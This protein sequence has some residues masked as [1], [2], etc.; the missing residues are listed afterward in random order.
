MTTASSRLLNSSWIESSSVV[1]LRRRSSECDGK[2]PEATAP[3]PGR[4]GFALLRRAGRLRGVHHPL[5]PL[6]PRRLLPSLPHHGRAPEL[7]EG[8]LDE[9]LGSLALGHKL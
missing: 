8:V 7:E 5:R 1:L 9:V 6:R 4:R 3:A 2:W